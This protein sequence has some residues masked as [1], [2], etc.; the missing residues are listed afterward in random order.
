MKASPSLVLAAVFTS[1]SCA[2]YAQSYAPTGVQ[3]NVPVATVASG[4]WTECF[5]ETFDKSTSDIASVSTACGGTKLMLACRPSGAATLTVLAQAPTT[6]VMFDTGNDT[7][8]VHS[9]NGVNWYFNSSRSWG[10]V[11]PGEA[12]NKNTC[13]TA[14]GSKKMCMHT[15]TG[16]IRGGYRCGGTANLNSSAAYERIIYSNTAAPAVAAPIPTVSEWG[17]IGLSSFMAIFAFA[18]MRRRK[19]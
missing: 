10:F 4:G 8:T 18:R 19:S 14:A 5:R 3:E 9:A 6:D 7:T 2:T 12:V 13:D 16:T 1:V 11:D 17:I 15:A